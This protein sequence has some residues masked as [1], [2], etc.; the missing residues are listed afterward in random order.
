MRVNGLL[1]YAQSVDGGGIDEYGEPVESGEIVWSDAVPCSVQFQTNTRGVYED[2][3]YKQ[4]RFQILVEE[5]P[6]D[7]SMLKLWRD[8]IYL[9]E[10]ELLGKP[11]KTTM[12]RTILYV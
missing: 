2:G 5:I 4:V 9:G 6:L 3:E 10:F 1:K 8:E 12:D 7:V 11:V